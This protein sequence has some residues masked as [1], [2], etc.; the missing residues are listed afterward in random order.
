MPAKLKTNLM[1]YAVLL[2]LSTIAITSCSTSRMFLTVDTKQQIEKANISLNQVQFFNS[3][4]IVL[5]RQLSKEDIGVDKGRIKI[6]NGKQIEEVIIPAYT[7]GVCELHDEKTFK[8][9]FETGDGKQI[10]FVAERR[11]DMVDKTSA[12]KIGANEW[13]TT[14]RGNKVGK[15]DYDGKVYTLVRGLDS[16]LMIEK[17]MLNNVDRDTRV[18]KGRKL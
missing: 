7:P 14:Q 8:I 17:S 5:V 1:K 4:E 18:A 16:R 10:A 3:E 6:E 2:A 11:N 13:I 12:F 9:S 15:V